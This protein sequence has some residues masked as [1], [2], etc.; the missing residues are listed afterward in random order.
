M[1]L[2]T[3]AAGKTGRAII[4]ALAGRG[5]RV[6]AFVHRDDQRQ[7]VLTSGATE[8]LVGDMLDDSVLD[9]AVKG[10]DAVYHICPNVS[11]DEVEIG[12]NVLSRS[13]A[14][15]VERFVY[16]SVLHPQTKD[17]PHHWAKLKVEELIL[18][19][20]LSYTILQPAAYMQNIL[21]I[22]DLIVERGVFRIPYPVETRISLIDLQDVA[23][24]VAKVI[25]NPIH[26]YA[27]Y[28]LV[29]PQGLSQEE[30]AQILSAELGF[31][32][33]AQ[34]ESLED[35]KFRMQK[36]E[37]GEY[38]IETLVKMFEYYA[39]YGFQGSPEVLRHLLQREPIDFRTF[40]RRRVPSSVGDSA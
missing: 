5:E 8:A 31:E 20:G 22:W 1:I 13:V 32:I 23:I 9:Q 39:K 29:G 19:S 40:L 18:Q 11:P 12:R 27:T 6:R 36:A 33:H 26:A 15:G 38:Q 24:V 25:H 17:M 14:H 28:E 30:I 7:I 35:W 4:K 10:V 3:G 37:M 34:Q 16:H 2:V 21:G